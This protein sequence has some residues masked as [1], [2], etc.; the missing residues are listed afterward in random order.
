MSDEKVRQRGPSEYAKGEA[1]TRVSPR[2][3]TSFLAKL[4]GLILIGLAAWIG[5]YAYRQGKL[6]DMTDEKQQKLMLDQ[7]KED[8]AKAE[9][10]A[11]EA[12]Q[13]FVSW[14]QRGI[15]DLRTRIKGKPPESKEE[16]SLLVDESKKEVAEVEK[17]SGKLQP[18]GVESAPIAVKK[19]ES[20]KALSKGEQLIS[21][22]RAHYRV[23]LAAYADTDPSAAQKLIQTRLREAEPHFVKSLDLLEQARIQGAG[24]ANLDSLEQSA[25][26]RLYDC[27]KRMELSRG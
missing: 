23:G 1:E 16:V 4:I 11:T 24:G 3:P 10:Q 15:D 12:S 6:P 8:I 21:E 5:W 17:G 19:S 25:A 14:A 22:A 26:K 20:D 13:K 18:G 2:R 27:R 7:A 9:S